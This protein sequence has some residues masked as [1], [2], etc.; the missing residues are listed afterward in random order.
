[1]HRCRHTLVPALLLAFSSAACGPSS[2]PGVD[3]GGAMALERPVALPSA[4]LE[5]HTGAP[6]DL[7]A[8]T[9]GDLTLVFFGYTNCPDICPVHM[10]NLAAVFRDLPLELTR[11][12]DVLFVTT[13][14]ERDTAERLESWLGSLHPRF[15]GLRGT[16]EQITALEAEMGIPVSVVAPEEETP[17]G[18]YFVGHAAQVLAFTADDTARVAYPW[19]TRQRDW[20]RDL[21]L[22]VEGETPDVGGGIIEV[23]GDR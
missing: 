17:D 9:P 16:R 1:M 18:G 11:R 15:V 4:V 8:D 23:E 3:S 12:V 6:F 2:A 5:D 13:D 22:L 7:R 21:P 20:L 14:P 10:A 19:G